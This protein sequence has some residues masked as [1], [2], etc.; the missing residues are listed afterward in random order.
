MKIVSD[1]QRDGLK[2]IAENESG[3]R[4]I[5]DVPAEGETG[6]GPTPMEAYLQA[7]VTCSAVDIVNI[8]KK[9]RLKLESLR[10]EA[11]AEKA[12]LPPKIFTD[13][14]IKFH[15]SGDGV[16]SKEMERAVR[17]SMD[18]FCSIK[19]MVDATKTKISVEYHIT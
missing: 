13:I 18:K 3:V 11:E 1:W 14:R 6:S 8:L 17:L 19:A 5:F 9:R 10:C 15:V 2:F 12:E 4:T 16:T 7:M